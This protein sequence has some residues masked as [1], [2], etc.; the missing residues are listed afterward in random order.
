MNLFCNDGGFLCNLLFTLVEMDRKVISLAQHKTNRD[1]LGAVRD[2]PSLF[3]SMR[4]LTNSFEIHW[5]GFVPATPDD[6]A[7][8][9]AGYLNA[10]RS[11]R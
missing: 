4:G 7:N 2:R 3:L 9:R 10:V 6:W 11:D 8:F 5:Y 1:Y